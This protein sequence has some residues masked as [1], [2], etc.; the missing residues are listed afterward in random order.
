MPIQRQPA[1]ARDRMLSV[2]DRLS[3]L[4]FPESESKPRATSEWGGPGYHLAVLRE[5]QDFWEDRGEEV[6]E[7]AEREME[8]D[9]AALSDVLTA[10]W[11]TPKPLDLAPYLSV[12]HP[13][14]EFCAPEPLCLLSGVAGSLLVWRPP[15]SGRWVGLSIGQADPEWPLQLLAASSDVSLPQ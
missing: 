7:A 3:V 13:D 15:A 10:R 9:L 1:A 6:V 2:V 14:P 5:S 8:A 11:G 12:D 4:P